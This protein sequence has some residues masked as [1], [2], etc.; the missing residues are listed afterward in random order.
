MTLPSRKAISNSPSKT[1]ERFVGGL[2]RAP[3]KLA[4]HLVHLGDH[5][6]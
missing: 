3:Y 2:V 1:I 4:L 5:P 6:R